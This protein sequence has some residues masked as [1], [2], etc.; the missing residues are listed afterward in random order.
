MASNVDPSLVYRPY[1]AVPAFAVAKPSEPG[2]T[3]LS[4][5]PRAEYDSLMSTR[6]H[7]WPAFHHYH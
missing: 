1:R 4:R 2:S 7:L 5:A 3:P 6:A